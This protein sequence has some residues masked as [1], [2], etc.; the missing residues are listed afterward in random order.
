MLTVYESPDVYSG[1]ATGGYYGSIVDVTGVGLIE[2]RDGPNLRNASDSFYAMI[3]EQGA[4]VIWPGYFSLD[5]SL[6]W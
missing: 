5:V 3:A 2:L 1:R 4:P 6:D